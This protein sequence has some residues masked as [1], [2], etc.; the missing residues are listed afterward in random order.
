MR[1]YVAFAA[2]VV[3]MACVLA[4]C[5]DDSKPSP[6]TTNPATREPKPGSAITARVR[7]V[8]LLGNPLA[9][10][11]PIATRQPNAFDEPFAKGPLSGSDGYSS[12]VLDT[13]QWL[14]VRAWDPATR[15][16]A[17]NYFDVPPG[18]AP[19]DKTLE[20]TMAPG[21]T[22]KAHLSGA[23][24]GPVGNETVGLMML[25]PDKGPW[26]PCEACTDA[27][28]GVVF[29]P[30][31]PGRFLLRFKA[32]ESGAAELPEVSLEPGGICDLGSVP[33]S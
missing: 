6:Q 20:I 16:F 11:A 14:Y 30:V 22:L 26:W 9:N 18:D 1:K 32:A 8:D 19:V 13:T 25:H 15:Y 7:I 27:E 4:G 33:L 28:G 21:A 17:N 23:G 3:G 5:G 2:I 24:G 29:S 31:P 10:M 12:I